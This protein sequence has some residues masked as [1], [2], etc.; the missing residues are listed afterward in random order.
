MTTIQ[1]PKVLREIDIIKDREYI[2]S[3]LEKS[4]NEPTTPLKQAYL[5]WIEYINN[6]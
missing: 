1:I 4:E 6:L 5:E 2:L 3:E